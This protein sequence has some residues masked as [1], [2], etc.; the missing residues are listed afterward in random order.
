MVRGRV[1]NSDWVQELVGDR[2][3]ETPA[4]GA[5]AFG[6]VLEP[7]GVHPLQLG[8]AGE[9]VARTV[10]EHASPAS[11]CY[12]NEFCSQR[13]VNSTPF[14]RQSRSFYSPRRGPEGLYKLSC[15]AQA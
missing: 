15:Q 1:G 14:L 2:R 12:A 13:R 6:P 5:V 4:F 8:A 11:I 10:Q 7:F 9:V 3:S